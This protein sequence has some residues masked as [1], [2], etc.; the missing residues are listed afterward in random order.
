MKCLS[1]GTLPTDT[2]LEPDPA[3]SG[4]SLCSAPTPTSPRCDVTLNERE[5]A[6]SRFSYFPISRSQKQGANS[7]NRE[8]CWRSMAANQAHGACLRWGRAP[9][10]ARPRAWILGIRLLHSVTE[11]PHQ[12]TTQPAA[13]PLSALAITPQDPDPGR[14]GKGEGLTQCNGAPTPRATAGPPPR[15]LQQMDSPSQAAGARSG[16][17]HPWTAPHSAHDGTKPAGQS[18]GVALQSSRNCGDRDW[19][20]ILERRMRPWRCAH[21]G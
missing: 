8:A 5:Q 10:A 16:S 11:Q 4:S 1:L 7:A 2:H 21:R 13:L 17:M 18:A 12:S 6:T 15:A 19:G 20:L 9:L 14:N 3:Q